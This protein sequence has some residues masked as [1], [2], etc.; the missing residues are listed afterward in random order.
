M[1][2]SPWGHKDSVRQHTAPSSSPSVRPSV[3]V[4]AASVW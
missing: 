2:D 4:Q 1:G 3:A